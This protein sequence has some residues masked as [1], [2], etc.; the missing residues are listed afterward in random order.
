[1]LNAVRIISYNLKVDWNLQKKKQKQKNVKE[2]LKLVDHG[3][4]EK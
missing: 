2:K 4:I 3:L 1:M